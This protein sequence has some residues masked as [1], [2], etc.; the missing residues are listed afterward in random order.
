MK[1]VGYTTRTKLRS[2][3]CILLFLITTDE[4]FSRRLAQE[5]FVP[6]NH[7]STTK[8]CWTLNYILHTLRQRDCLVKLS[9]HIDYGLNE[10][11]Q[12][13]TCSNSDALWVF[14]NNFQNWIWTSDKSQY[15]NA[16][17]GEPIISPHQ[18]LNILNQRCCWGDRRFTFQ[19]L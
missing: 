2:V 13:F 19:L 8:N 14:S 7:N 18:L 4:R 15:V 6:I 3:S 11:T 5:P 17:N 16:V 1:L 9:T 10:L 12:I